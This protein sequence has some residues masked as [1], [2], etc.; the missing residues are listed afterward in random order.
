MPETDV[1]QQPKKKKNGCMIAI[2]AFAVIAILGIGGFLLVGGLFVTGAAVAVDQAIKEENRIPEEIL[3]LDGSTQTGEY[4][5]TVYD[6]QEFAS[7]GNEFYS[8][9]ASE[10]ATFVAVLWGYKNT[11][12]TPISAFDAPRIELLSPDLARYEPAV[13]ASSALAS[14]ID[15]LNQKAL[16]DINPGISVKTVDVFE[17]SQELLLQPGWTLLIKADEKVRMKLN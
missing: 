8:E 7:V 13:G 3:P 11:T 10:G 14:T 15:G 6:I 2:I 5:I 12:G 9:Q 16:S 17:V 4:E 1:P